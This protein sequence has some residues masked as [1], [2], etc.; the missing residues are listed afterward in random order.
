MAQRVLLV[1]ESRPVATAL[2][3]HLEGAGFRVDLARPAEALGRLEPGRHALAVVRA[4]AARESRLAEALKK[5]DPALQVVL[6]FEDE[7]EDLAGELELVADGI[8]VGPLSRPA[9]VSLARA[10][11]R[12][13]AQARRIESLTR[14]LARAAGPGV[15]DLEL[16]RRLLLMETRRSRR[17][18]YPVALALVAVDR[19]REALAGVE[20]RARAAW[21]AELLG[22]ITRAVRD[23]DLA[24]LYSPDRFLVLMPHTGPEGALEVANRL[25]ARIRS[26]RGPVRATCS[27]GVAAFD[28]EGPVSF[29]TLTR[30]AAEALGRAQEG[31]GDRALLAG[32][33]RRKRERVFIG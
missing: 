3:R 33:G 20:G 32:T 23:I 18:R 17:Y 11:A 12:L 24:V 13:R 5:A 21:L 4:E 26:H 7:D 6:V 15:A 2:R 29:S 14:A 31:G 30:Q 28:G 9:V 22:V 10:M 25:V 1:E 19:L 27:V 16:L 8:L